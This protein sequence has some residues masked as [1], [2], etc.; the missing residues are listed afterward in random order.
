MIETTIEVVIS[1]VLIVAGIAVVKCFY[2]LVIH[3]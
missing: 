3:D 1:I 2:D